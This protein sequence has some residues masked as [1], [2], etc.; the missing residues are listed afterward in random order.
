LPLL[1]HNLPDIPPPA[2]A[3]NDRQKYRSVLS[4]LSKLCVQPSLFETLVIRI[5]TKLDLLSSQPSH[6]S[7]DGDVEMDGNGDEARECLVS[8]AWDLL[9]CLYNVINAKLASKH[10]DVVKYFDIII[11]KLYELVI[12]ASAPVVGD[13][14]PLFRD[15]RLLGIV[16]KISEKLMWELNVEWVTWYILLSVTN[17]DEKA[18]SQAICSCVCCFRKGGG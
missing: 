17:R 6:R 10:V 8:Y 9:S 11:P 15:R 4:S 16:G 5:T 7:G 18:T 1:F 14:Q 13:S 2:H 12:S 3:I